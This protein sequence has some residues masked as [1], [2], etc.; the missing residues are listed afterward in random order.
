LQGEIDRR[1]R[2]I[3]PDYVVTGLL[4]DG[5]DVLIDLDQV[6]F[7]DLG[8][9]RELH[10]ERVFLATCGV[11]MKIKEPGRTVR[12]TIHLCG[13]DEMIDQTVD[14]RTGRRPALRPTKKK[15]PSA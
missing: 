13:L 12:R 1:C 4:A 10:N 8:A 6:T 2:P 5:D 14:L 11:D 15:A 3:L 9:I 7:V